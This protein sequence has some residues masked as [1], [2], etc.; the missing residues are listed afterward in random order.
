MGIE[1][2]PLKR[3]SLGAVADTKSFDDFDDIRDPILGLTVALNCL[4]NGAAAPS[5]TEAFTQLG[6]LQIKKGGSSVINWDLDDYLQYYHNKYGYPPIKAGAQADNNVYRFM[7][8]VLFGESYPWWNQW[9][10][11]HGLYRAGKSHSLELVVPAD[12]N[13]LDGRYVDIAA[14]VNAGGGKPETFLGH[15]K[16]TPTMTSGAEVLVDLGE[17]GE[18]LAEVFAFQTTNIDDGVA[19]ET[20]SIEDMRILRNKKEDIVR[21]PKLENLQAFQDDVNSTDAYLYWALRPPVKLDVP[22]QLGFTAGDANATRWYPGVYYKN[23]A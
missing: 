7:F 12:G 15:L 1:I 2:I 14:I 9:D 22:T 17:T 11:N 5:T 19:A 4:E 20:T 3:V 10:L 18:E 13:K 8:V 21:K 6:D 16:Q 23:E